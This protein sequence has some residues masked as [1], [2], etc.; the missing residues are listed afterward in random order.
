MPLPMAAMNPE[1]WAQLMAM[2]GGG[3]QGEQSPTQSGLFQGLGSGIQGLENWYAGKDQRKLFKQQ[4]GRGTDLYNL[5]RSRSGYGQDV[6]NPA[7]MNKMLAYWR[8]AMNPTFNQLGGNAARMGSM[9][10]PDI[11]KMLMSARIGPEAQF[12]GNLQQQN[13]EL[14]Q[15]RNQYLGQLLAR[16]AG[17]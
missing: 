7:M 14:T 6:I 13:L 2:T 10:S 11:Q 1:T 8:T 15:N 5:F 12:T 9:S 4:M 3:N 16:L 17:V